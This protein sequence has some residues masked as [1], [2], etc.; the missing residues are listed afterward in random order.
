MVSLPAPPVM[1]SPPVEPVMVSL[2]APPRTPVTA[3]PPTVP[4]AVMVSPALAP[5]RFRT[6]MLEKDDTEVLLKAKLTVSVPLPP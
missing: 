1:V 2:P 6:W 3:I 5:T 4:L